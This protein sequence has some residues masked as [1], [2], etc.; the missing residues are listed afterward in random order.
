MTKV[1]LPEEKAR[2]PFNMI[3]SMMPMYPMI[4]VMG[5]MFVGIAFLV[6]LFALAPAQSAFFS[7]AKA[8]RE[9]AGAGSLFVNANVTSHVI[10]AWLPQFKFLGLG[11]GLMAITM[12]LGII[13][14]KLRHMGMTITGHMSSDYR[15]P[16][17]PIPGSVR[18]FQLSTMMGLM[19]LLAV[20]IV[21]IVLATG[22]VP[23]YW[24]NSIANVL[25]QAQPGSALLAQ[26]GVVKSFHFWLNP[27][28][29]VGMSFLFTAITIALTVIIGTLRQQA[30]LL[31]GFF[32]QASN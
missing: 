22:V 7:D 26:L 16:M 18:W 9:A 1:K 6:G 20:L 23:A 4:A 10:E 3:E 21:G 15:P 2:F 24:N 32:Y 14:K 11:L 8:L 31:V 13:A 30:K 25:N 29:M 17:P 12:A 27:L 28:R 19:V 5:W